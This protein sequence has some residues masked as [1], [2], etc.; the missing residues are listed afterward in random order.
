MEDRRRDMKN[1]DNHN[2]FSFMQMQFKAITNRGLKRI[3][4]TLKEQWSKQQRSALQ[5]KTEFLTLSESR[6]LR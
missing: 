3:S 1:T 5:V 6:F 2:F 4:N